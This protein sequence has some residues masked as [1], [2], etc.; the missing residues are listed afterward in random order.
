MKT[1]T[2]QKQG[3]TWHKKCQKDYQESKKNTKENPNNKQKTT[4]TSNQARETPQI[5]SQAAKSLRAQTA[6]TA[7]NKSETTKRTTKP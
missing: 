4:K 5:T 2:V 1:T 7:I 6:R 3:I